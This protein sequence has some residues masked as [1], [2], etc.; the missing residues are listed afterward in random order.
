LD[1]LGNMQK[2]NNLALRLCGALAVLS[3]FAYAA[4]WVQNMNIF[5]PDTGLA[6][7]GAAPSVFFILYMVCAVLTMCAL[8]LPVLRSPLAGDA[9]A[10]RC[11][12]APVGKALFGAA[13]GITILGG[14]LLLLTGGAMLPRVLA[15]LA[16]SPGAP[17][18]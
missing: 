11:T 2:T 12:D 17:W 3:A 5:D 14:A 13:G 6:A 18:H 8:L 10:M 15:I 4:R 16:L 9:A 1:G 7:P